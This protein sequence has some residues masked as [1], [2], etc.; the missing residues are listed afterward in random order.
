MR[1]LK[2]RH[3]R[4]DAERLVDRVLG[5]Q[6]RATRAQ[7]GLLLLLA[8]LSMLAVPAVAG[9]RG[10]HRHH[11]RARH[12]VRRAHR[13]S[14]SPAARTRQ[15]VTQTTTTATT[16]AATSPLAGMSFYVDPNSAAAQQVTAWASSNPSGAAEIE[17][18][19]S[20]PV[21]KWFGDWNT[22]V[23]SSVN[24]TVSAAASSGKVPILVAYDIPER[25]CGGY[26]SGGA[27][28]ASAYQTWIGQFA[29]GIGSRTAVVVLEPDA[30]ALMSCL[31]AADQTT[32]LS[33]L[34]YAV[35]TLSAHAGAHVYIDAGHE[36]W[37]GA[38][39]MAQR[40]T[41]AGVA[42]AQGFSLNVSNFYATSG[43]ESYGA[44]ISSLIGGRHF[45]ID[46]SRN[47]NGPDGQW[48]NPPD[49]ALGN[50]PTAS[51][52]NALTD[53]FLWIKTPG[54]SDGTCNGG[55]SAGTWW[56]SYALMLAQ[57]AAY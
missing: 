34:K 35:Q 23:Q 26:S 15:A 12:H 9:A 56:A 27:T 48:C 30:L 1:T 44:S 39:T 3:R 18:I 29:A 24:T 21:A 25:D 37:V 53:A 54:A 19:A 28:S 32:R 55:P 8:A 40:L 43:E 22:N 16:T 49:R 13:P 5:H 36:N 46:T 42:Q 17:K 52:G 7:R 38:S 2:R 51:T 47:G 10:I 20:Q 50:R 31:S 45:V 57:N 6:P 14:M 33:L 41:A 4:A 11:H